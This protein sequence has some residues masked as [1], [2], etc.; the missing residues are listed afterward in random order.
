[1][2]IDGNAGAQR[3][4]EDEHVPHHGGV[5]QYVLFWP[6][7]DEDED[8][9]EDEDGGKDGRSSPTTASNKYSSGLE[10]GE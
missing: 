6:D 3:F 10:M 8:D 4:G 7:H 5:G 1:M 2:S 9:D